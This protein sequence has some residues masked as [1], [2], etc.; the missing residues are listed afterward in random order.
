ME[1]FVNPKPSR[2][3]RAFTTWCPE[4]AGAVA[5]LGVFAPL[6]VALVVGNGMSATAALLPAG[7]LYLLAAWVYRL[8]VGVQPL[9][10]LAAVAIAN[11]LPPETIGAAALWMGI[12][13][14]ALG[15]SG[16][17]DNLARVFPQALVRGVQAA[18]GLLLIRSAV[19]LVWQPPGPFLPYAL[20]LDWSIALT[21]GVLVL[22]IRLRRLHV[23]LVLVA[24]GLVI[25][26][27]R[28]EGEMLWGPSGM[29]GPSTD[30]AIWWSALV[31]LVLPQ[32]PLTLA[33]ACIAPVDAARH[34]FGDKAGSVKPG[35]LACTLGAANLV[36]GAISGLP[37]C[38]GSGGMTAH[39]AFGAR[40]WRAPLLIGS[41]MVLLALVAGQGLGPVLAAFPV[42]ILAGLLAAAGMLHLALLAA[43]KNRKDQA[44]ALTVGLV[45][46]AT[47]NLLWGLLAG[48]LLWG[49]LR[50]VSGRPPA[51]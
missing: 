11:G 6:A 17:L 45:G 8:P 19:M 35:R 27:G 37:V 33:N 38:H 25:A 29:A 32:A 13:F 41:A 1:S 4:A 5:D 18:V 47:L 14:T 48:G 30:P 28:F 39:V 42:E 2:W 34:Y 23:T 36:A 9:K 7:L 51:R 22:A 12:L 31:A 26:L 43:L 16:W 10:A 44:I 46:A 20:P 50:L 49:L 3:T 21:V 40:S 15:V 24:A